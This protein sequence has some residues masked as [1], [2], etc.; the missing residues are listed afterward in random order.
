M[1]KPWVLVASAAAAAL[2]AVVAVV[3]R[4]GG[5]ISWVELPAVVLFVLFV[6]LLFVA[7]TSPPP[8]VA[9]GAA[10]SW[11]H[12]LRLALLVGNPEATGESE[13]LLAKPAATSTKAAA[14]AF[15]FMTTSALV[16]GA[17]IPLVVWVC[18]MGMVGLDLLL[19]S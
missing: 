1:K 10:C 15:S 18:D 4:G 12:C 7:V 13:A 14:A 16:L 19:V 8:P 17:N 9:E 11:S 5:N 6:I 3:T 2:A